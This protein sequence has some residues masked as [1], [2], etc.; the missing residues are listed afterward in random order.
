MPLNTQKYGQNNTCTAAFWHQGQSH[1]CPGKDE[2]SINDALNHKNF[3]LKAEC[4]C[5]LL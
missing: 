3:K 2:K 4:L 1:P 5:C